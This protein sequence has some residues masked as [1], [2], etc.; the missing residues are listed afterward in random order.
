MDTAGDT[1][2]YPGGRKGVPAC[3]ESALASR[4]GEP[5]GR[6]KRDRARLARACACARHVKQLFALGWSLADL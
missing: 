4:V 3:R 5:G 1:N 2:G 6:G